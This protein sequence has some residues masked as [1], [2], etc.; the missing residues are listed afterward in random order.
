M[1]NIYNT[2]FVIR[3]Y[4]FLNT[5]MW[6]IVE[7]RTNGIATTIPRKVYPFSTAI[8]H[9]VKYHTACSGTESQVHIVRGH[10]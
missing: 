7:I 9:V 4:C 6:N 1:V 8:L 10:D 2:T 5:D 3:K